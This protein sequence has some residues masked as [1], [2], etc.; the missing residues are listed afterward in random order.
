MTGALIMRDL[1]RWAGRALWLPIIFF[2][3]TIMLVPFATG[4]DAVLLE[5]VGPGMIMIAALLASLLPIDRLVQPDLVDGT[6]DQLLLRGVS[7]EWIGLTKGI[8]HWLS[9]GPPLMVALLPASAL[10]ALSGDN[11]AQIALALFIATPALA[12]L[13]VAIAAIA[14]NLERA[15]SLGGLLMLPLAVPVL[16]FGVSA[17]RGEAGAL[18]LLG[19]VSLFLGVISPFIVGA[20][21]R[22]RS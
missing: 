12:G 21:L 1:K 13:T 22:Q 20:A 2:L 9:F 19:A 15:A 17:A 11:V 18:A 3:M 16:I 10:L 5:R 14:A 4:P 8:A 6:I 7:P